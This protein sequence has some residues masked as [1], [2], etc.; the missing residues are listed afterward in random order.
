MARCCP[1]TS[2]DQKK[3]EGGRGV[4]GGLV[5]ELRAVTSVCVGPRLLDEA[6]VSLQIELP[7]L[8]I[9]QLQDTQ[10]A[11][12]SVQSVLGTQQYQATFDQANGTER[13]YI[14]ISKQFF[15]L[16]CAEFILI[17]LII[18]KMKMATLKC[19]LNVISD[20]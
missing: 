11:I 1:N 6:A 13:K 10:W 12:I 8:K 5:G 9:I 7:P 2:R 20:I 17:E 15:C 4:A 19:L 16:F 14:I 18:K 3:K